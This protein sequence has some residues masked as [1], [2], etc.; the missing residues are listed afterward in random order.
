MRS[1]VKATRDSNSD[2]GQRGRLSK[3]SVR[4]AAVLFVSTAL[5]LH[6][7]FALVLW[8]QGIRIN[9]TQFSTEY[10]KLLGSTFVSVLVAFA[11]KRYDR[12]QHRAHA[13]LTRSLAMERLHSIRDALHA[14]HESSLIHYNLDA[15]LTERA[16]ADKEHKRLCELILS[17]LREIRARLDALTHEARNHIGELDR[18]LVLL[19]DTLVQHGRSNTRETADALRLRVSD[20]VQQ[21]ST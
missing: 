7:P 3:R 21:L 5:S 1:V 12:Q 19:T 10:A 20:V 16:A 11:W 17:L 15:P 8:A 14:L 2:S 9:P 18:C 4:T 13:E 6:V